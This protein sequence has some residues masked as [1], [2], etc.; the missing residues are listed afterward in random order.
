MTETR[1][2]IAVDKAL[3]Q[4]LQAGF[5]ELTQELYPGEVST[6]DGWMLLGWIESKG[7]LIDMTHYPSTMQWDIYLVDD[8]GNIGKARLCD[9]YLCLLQA[10]IKLL[11]AMKGVD[12]ES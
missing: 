1:T 8:K 7:W 2:A 9:R 4:R 3:K 5:V 12:G 11:T 10:L 6:V